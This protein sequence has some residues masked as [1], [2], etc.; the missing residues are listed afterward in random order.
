MTRRFGSLLIITLLILSGLACSNLAPAPVSGEL[1]FQDDFSL[2]GSGWDRSED[3]AVVMD[4]KQGGYR[5]ELLSAN[6]IA[7]ATPGLDMNGVRI[8][9]DARRIDG[10][11]NNYFGLLCGKDQPD[12]FYIFLVSSDGY[13]GI[14]EYLAGEINL[15]SHDSMLPSFNINDGS[16]RNH[17]RADCIGN[18]LSFF[19]N[20]N[21]EMEVEV[22]GNVVGDVGFIV[23]SNQDAGVN[24]QFDNFSVYQP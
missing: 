3:N 12:H 18:R 7:W 23:G 9:A 6:S 24:I 14:G 2:T 22:A 15:L 1:L 21:L 8:E 4:Y 13:A 20:L 10:S 19:I 17:L 5:M 16:A 11:E